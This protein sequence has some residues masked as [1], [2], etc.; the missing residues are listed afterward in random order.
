M[1]RMYSLGGVREWQD[2]WI[3]ALN[4]VETSARSV[5]QKDGS[6]REVATYTRKPKPIY[7]AQGRQVEMGSDHVLVMTNLL[8]YADSLDGDSVQV[9]VGVEQ[10][11]LRCNCSTRK[12]DNL[13]AELVAANFI[14]RSKRTG[15][16]VSNTTLSRY[17]QVHRP[18]SPSAS[19]VRIPFRIARPHRPSAHCVRTK[20]LKK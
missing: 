12:L 11:A 3:E 14:A 2:S 10:L 8:L 13:L 6:Y 20:Y 17:P 15:K 4:D 9:A 18:H 19:R 7:D 16:S 5:R 1:A